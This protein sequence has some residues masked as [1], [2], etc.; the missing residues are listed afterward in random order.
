MKEKRN[1]NNVII[2][3]PIKFNK[4][5]IRYT[6]FYYNFS[7]YFFTIYFLSYFNYISLFFFIEKTIL[8]QSIQVLYN[9]IYI[10]NLIFLSIKNNYYC[11]KLM[12]LNYIGNK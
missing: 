9:Y 2:E 8:N 1:F 10:Y 12:I 3:M 5:I 7:K 6:Y 4:S 11:T